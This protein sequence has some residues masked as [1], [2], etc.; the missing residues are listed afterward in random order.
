M[1]IPVDNLR[2]AL[3]RLHEQGF[4]HEGDARLTTSTLEN[5]SE[6]V[7]TILRRLGYIGELRQESRFY[8]GHGQIAW[9][10]DPCAMS[11]EEAVR[12]MDRYVPTLPRD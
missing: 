9:M 6:D 8:P 5:R 2:P 11:R 10:Y 1:D 4:F 3:A 7:A 12:R